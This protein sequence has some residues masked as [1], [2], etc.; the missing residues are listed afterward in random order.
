MCVQKGKVN[1]KNLSPL[2]LFLHK[3]YYV[4]SVKRVDLP[5]FTISRDSHEHP[6]T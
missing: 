2:F 3:F 1:K 5:C 4:Y 6:H